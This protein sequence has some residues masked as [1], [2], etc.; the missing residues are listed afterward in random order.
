[1][2]AGFEVSG[3]VDKICPS[4]KYCRLAVGDRVVVYPTEEELAKTGL[5]TVTL[6][7]GGQ[8]SQQFGFG[9]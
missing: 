2:F 3:I 8:A 6:K 7:P 1:M 9:L 4:V 5:V